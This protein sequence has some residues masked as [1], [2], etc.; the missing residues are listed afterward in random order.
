MNN[1]SVKK[2][3]SIKFCEFLDI[4]KEKNFHYIV[5][6]SA[7]AVMSSSRDKWEETINAIIDLAKECNDGDE[8]LKRL[9]EDFKQ[10]VYK[11]TPEA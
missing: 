10:Y 6:L 5:C 9:L 3:Q 1:E 8:F 2:K 7:G 11:V 4:A